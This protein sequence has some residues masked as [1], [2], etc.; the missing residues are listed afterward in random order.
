MVN[1]VL[2]RQTAR[3]NVLCGGEIRGEILGA[4]Q[5]QLKSQYSASGYIDGIN[6]KIGVKDTDGVSVELFKTEIISWIEKSDLVSLLKELEILPETGQ[7]L[8]LD[9]F[10]GIPVEVTVENVTINGNIYSNV[11]RIKKIAVSNDASTEVAPSIETQIS[12][13]SEY[14]SVSPAEILGVDLDLD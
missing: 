13:I 8:N 12:N 6:I 2:V 4:W 14:K 3:Y 9:N 1:N 11:K 5:K 7:M 10:R